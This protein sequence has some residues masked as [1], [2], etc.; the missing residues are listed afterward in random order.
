M[1]RRSV[2]KLVISAGL[3][4]LPLLAAATDCIGV[5]LESAALEP[6]V[7]FVGETETALDLEQTLWSVRSDGTDRVVVTIMTADKAVDIVMGGE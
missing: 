2:N 3:V 6:A 1:K 4:M 5:I 7:F